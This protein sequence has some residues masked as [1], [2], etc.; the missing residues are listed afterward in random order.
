MSATIFKY[1]SFASQAQT[2]NFPCS[3]ALHHNKHHQFSSVQSL[4]HVWLFVTPWTA[5]CQASLSITNS[6]SL[7]KLMSIES[8]MPSNHLILC[9]PLLFPPSIFPSIRVFSNKSVLRRFN[10]WVRKIPWR[11][12]W[13]PSPVFLPGELH[14]QWS[15]ASYSPMGCKELDTAEW[16]TQL[17]QWR[18][19]LQC[20]KPGFNPWVG[21]IPWRRKCNPL[22]YSCLENSTDRGA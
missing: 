2:L 17:R 6:W 16:L 3:P 7:L 9:C 14:G 22:Q 5:A 11:K 15:L 10:P 12:E 20:R 21:K 1:M 4:S 8:V 18:I 13:L 19:C